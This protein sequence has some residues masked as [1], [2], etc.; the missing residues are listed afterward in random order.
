L[1]SASTE[2]VNSVD[3]G[4]TVTARVRRYVELCPGMRLESFDKL[5]T[6]PSTG[7]GQ[8]S[9][10]LW[11]AP[12]N[13]LLTAPVEGRLRGLRRALATGIYAAVHG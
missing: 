3:I 11:T 1:S 8:R 7:S 5:R 2:M 13:K 10:K 12:S 9:N 4:P 6:R